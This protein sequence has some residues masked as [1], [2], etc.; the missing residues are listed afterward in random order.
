M[1]DVMQKNLEA[2]VET[3]FDMSLKRSRFLVKNFTDGN[4]SVRLGNNT[5]HSIIGARCFE[6][7]F[8]NINNRVSTIPE[9]TDTVLVIADVPG[10]V[11]VASVD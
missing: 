6:V 11:E 8:N 4:I 5:G 9:V 1:K 2:G 3:T 10:L 7:V